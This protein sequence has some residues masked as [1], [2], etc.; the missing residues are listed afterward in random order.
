MGCG[1]SNMNLILLEE[2]VLGR[3]K[4]RFRTHKSTFFNFAKLGAAI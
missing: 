3:S 4:S 2:K 1:K